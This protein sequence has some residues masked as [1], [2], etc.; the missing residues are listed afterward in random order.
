MGSPHKV[1]DTD[2]TF[3]DILKWVV[4]RKQTVMTKNTKISVDYKVVNTDPGI[5]APVVSKSINQKLRDKVI[6]EA[7][8][9]MQALGFAIEDLWY[10][11]T[12]NGQYKK[13][14]V[15][16]G[17]IKLP[18]S[19]TSILKNPS[20]ANFEMSF[21]KIREYVS[22]EMAVA[23]P[24]VGVQYLR[25]TDRSGIFNSVKDAAITTNMVAAQALERRKM[26]N[27]VVKLV[28]EDAKASVWPEELLV[29]QAAITAAKKAARKLLVAQKTAKTVKK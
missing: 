29:K 16:I 3:F 18:D 2:R 15:E 7:S 27:F 4:C 20:R 14:T 21:P 10:F 28:K 17:G 8:S 19:L 6:I 24:S 9:F 25:E 11:L 5:D 26:S 13:S 12:E 1:G 22:G 23:S